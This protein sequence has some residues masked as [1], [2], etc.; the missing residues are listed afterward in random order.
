MTI[1]GL[2][3]LGIGTDKLDEGLCLRRWISMSY[4]HEN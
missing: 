3:Y 2:G 4:L 1:Q